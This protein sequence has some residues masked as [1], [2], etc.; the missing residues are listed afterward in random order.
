MARGRWHVGT[1]VARVRA[2]AAIG[3]SGLDAVDRAERR[4]EVLRIAGG[5]DS[6]RLGDDQA[7][8]AFGRIVDGLQ[9]D[10]PGSALGA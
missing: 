1:I 8:A 2:S 7:I 6:G 10:L 5:V 9:S 4:A 3:A